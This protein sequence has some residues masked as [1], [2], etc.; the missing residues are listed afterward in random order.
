MNV[1]IAELRNAVPSYPS[2]DEK[3][4]RA[5]ITDIAARRALYAHMYQH[6]CV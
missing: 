2:F 6:H 1:Q 4:Q 3:V 5:K